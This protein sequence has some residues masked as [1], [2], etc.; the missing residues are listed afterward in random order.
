MLIK[1]EVIYDLVHSSKR[2]GEMVYLSSVNKK[3]WWLF[4]SAVVLAAA[5]TLVIL[6]YKN[7]I[8]IY[9]EMSACSEN[10]EV[11]RITLDG[12]VYRYLFYPAELRGEITVDGTHYRSAAWSERYKRVQ[13]TKN[14]QM[15]LSERLQWKQEG[16]FGAAPLFTW[17]QD[18]GVMTDL[19]EGCVEIF[20]YDHAT[21]M[22]QFAFLLGREEGT[23]VFYAP[24]VNPADAQAIR[25]MLSTDFS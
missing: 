11:V 7:P 22:Q 15:S 17:V 8:H 16:R 3:K 4:A 21:D 18:N 2:G 19:S 12:Y 6:L 9:R 5:C 20:L 23:A 13:P 24:A 14:S 1:R 10:G 25:S